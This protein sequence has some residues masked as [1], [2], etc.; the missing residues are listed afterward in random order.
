M[1]QLTYW[2]GL[3]ARESAQFMGC[4]TAAVWVR[5]TRA[6]AALRELL[7]WDQGERG[8]DLDGQAGTAS[9]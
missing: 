3:T 1:L 9:A 6:R 4:S 2:D 8:G 5:L 7:E